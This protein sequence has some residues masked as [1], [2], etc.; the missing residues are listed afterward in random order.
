MSRLRD[1]AR[2][3]ARPRSHAIGFGRRSE[4]PDPFVVVVASV[5]GAAEAGAAA[6][7]EAGALLYTGPAAGAAAIV[8][9]AGP[10]PVGCELAG[11]T[12]SDAAALL[13]AGV[14]FLVFDDLLSEAAALA[15]PE[16]GRVAR[17]GPELDGAALRALATLDLDAALIAP[18]SAAAGGGPLSVRSLAAAR[19]RSS[20]LRA[21]LAVDAR[22]RAGE[23]DP[24]TVAAWRDA[25]APLLVVPAARAEAAV[26]ASRS[27]PPPAPRPRERPSA[28]LPAPARWDADDE[29][30]DG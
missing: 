11:A 27:V 23:L 20:L 28:T 21:P 18:P 30:E 13:D 14:D 2:Q 6:S 24:A 26:A 29:E 16:L 9:V 25:G 22:G 17:I 3:A 15:R 10:R 12:G 1:L 5:D 7:A 4:P 8:S 19:R